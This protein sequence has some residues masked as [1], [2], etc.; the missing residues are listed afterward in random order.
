MTQKLETYVRAVLAVVVI[1]ITFMVTQH[2][3]SADSLPKEWEA[4]FVLVI[5]YYFADR[6]QSNALRQLQ[7]ASP[8]TRAEIMT[9]AL[10]ATRIELSAQ[11]CVA[12]ALVA[13]TAALFLVKEGHRTELAGA[14]IAGV[15]LA[16]GF[17]FKKTDTPADPQLS[18]FRVMIAAGIIGA[19]VP[20][21]AVCA[22]APPPLQWI[23]LVLIAIAFY[24]KER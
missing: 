17:Y 20:I 21:S 5:G 22:W 18:I 7:T 13:A 2:A 19:T 4:I 14:W 12:A 9:V 15:A 1:I 24:F 8:E 11:F 3:P 16:V 6:P 23:S 10:E